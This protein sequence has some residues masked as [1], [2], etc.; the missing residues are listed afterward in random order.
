MS[1]RHPSNPSA[2]SDSR[3]TSSV[4]PTSLIF[5][6]L[7]NASHLL[8]F[9]ASTFQSMVGLPSAANNPVWVITKSLS[10]PPAANVALP[11]SQ[12]PSFRKSH[13]SNPLVISS[14]GVWVMAWN[15]CC[16]SGDTATTTEASSSTFFSIFLCQRSVRRVMDRCLK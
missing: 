2:R 3:I 8:H 9:S 13:S 14:T 6:A 16:T 12:A 1:V 7:A 5:R 11:P 15:S 10:G 4:F